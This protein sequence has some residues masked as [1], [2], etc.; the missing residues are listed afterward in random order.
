MPPLC[1]HGKLQDEL[2][3]FTGHCTTNAA[4]FSCCLNPH[5]TAQPSQGMLPKFL[6][7]HYERHEHYFSRKRSN[8]ELNCILWKQQDTWHYILNCVKYSCCLNICNNSVCMLPCLC[9]KYKMFVGQRWWMALTS[10]WGTRYDIL[11]VPFPGVLIRLYPTCTPPRCLNTIT[12]YL[13][14]SQ[15]F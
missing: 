10:A 8:Y 7:V 2:Y 15:M 12:S 4:M 11:P 3:I 9:L 5:W 14:P 13:H 6:H 1:L